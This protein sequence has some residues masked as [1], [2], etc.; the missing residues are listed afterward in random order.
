MI[1]LLGG[2]SEFGGPGF[3]PVPEALLD[4]DLESYRENALWVFEFSGEKSPPRSEG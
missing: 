3:G 1:T 2:N 4:E